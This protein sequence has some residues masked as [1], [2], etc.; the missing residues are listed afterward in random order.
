[1]RL[2]QR[3]PRPMLGEG[4]P[5]PRKRGRLSAFA[6][7]HKIRSYLVLLFPH[8]PSRCVELGRYTLVASEAGG[9]FGLFWGG[10]VLVR[11][12]LAEMHASA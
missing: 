8:L 12:P 4:I 5:G 7:P 9:C 2:K 6:C 3:L 11:A 10:E 1:M